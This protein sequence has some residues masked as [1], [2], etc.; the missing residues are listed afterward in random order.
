MAEPVISYL[1][2]PPLMDAAAVNEISSTT[3]V[4]PRAEEREDALSPTRSA[5]VRGPDP[6]ST[7][8]PNGTGKFMPVSAS[9]GISWASASGRISPDLSWADASRA[10]V[11]LE[12]ETKWCPPECSI[13][14]ARASSTSRGAT[15]AVVMDAPGGSC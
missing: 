9:P 13:C 3:A 2:L 5:R 14:D 15:L 1:P 11:L 4:P 8:G 10:A 7:G 6:E 12:I